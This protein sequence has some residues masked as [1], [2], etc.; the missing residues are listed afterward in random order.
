MYALPARPI[1]VT[2]LVINTIAGISNAP[3]T[4]ATAA[5]KPATD[6]TANNSGISPTIVFNSCTFFNDL[7]APPPTIKAIFIA[8]KATDINIIGGAINAPATAPIVAGIINND[9]AA[10]SKPNRPTIAII[11]DTLLSVFFAPPPIKN[12]TFI[13]PIATP[14]KVIGIAIAAAAI[15]PNI[16][17][18]NKSERPANKTPNPTI[19]SA[20]T[21][22]FLSVSNA[23]PPI[24]N[25]TFI[26]PIATPNN[27][28]T[29]PI[30][31]ATNNPGAIYGAI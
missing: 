22:T 23:P 12:A 26:A 1:I 20:I 4:I 2:I 31:P 15:A 18:T 10:N 13:A 5:A 17:G 30:A 3:V 21:P 27:V 7:L 8:I 16:A 6:I 11:F 24:K 19:M 25:A 14:N 28:I 29:P 9:I